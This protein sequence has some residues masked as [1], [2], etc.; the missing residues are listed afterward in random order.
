M[1]PFTSAWHTSHAHSDR[2]SVSEPTLKG[3]GCAS[4]GEN[5]W[6]REPRCTCV[7]RRLGLPAEGRTSVPLGHLATHKSPCGRRRRRNSKGSVRA[8]PHRRVGALHRMAIY[9]HGKITRRNRRQ[10]ISGADGARER[11]TRKS[12]AFGYPLD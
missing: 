3:G 6:R 2:L 5:Y 10:K 7:G 1:Q 9:D 8:S 4:Y 11:G 12:T